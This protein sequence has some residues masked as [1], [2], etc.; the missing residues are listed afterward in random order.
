MKFISPLLLMITACG[1]SSLPARLIGQA[2]QASDIHADA[3]LAGSAL[4]DAPAHLAAPGQHSAD[5]L[6]VQS[7]ARVADTTQPSGSG[8]PTEDAPP[9]SDRKPANTLAINQTVRDQSD[10]QINPAMFDKHLL[11]NRIWISGQANFIFQ[12]HGAFHSPYAGTNSFQSTREQTALSRVLT[13]YTGVRFAKYSEF[14]FDPEETGGKGLSEALGIA[15]FTNLD[16]VRNPSL[17]QNVYLGRYMLHETIPLSHETIKYD[18]NPFYLAQEVPKKRIEIHF[19][20]MG[21]VDFFDVNDVGSDSHL[22]FTN[23]SLDNNGAYDYAADTR[24]YTIGAVIEYQSPTFGIRFGEA[25]MPTVANGITLDY[26]LRRARAQNLELEFRPDWLPGKKT[27]IRPLAYLNDANMGDYRQAINAYLDGKDATPDVTLHRHQGSVKQGF[28]IN[29]EQELPK[30]LRVFGRVGWNEGHKE[31]F[32]YTEINNTFTLGADVSGEAWHRPLDKIGSAFADN[33]IS[34]DHREYLA[35]GGLG[36]ILG[37]GRLNYGREMI[38]E[39]YY[40][41]H[42]YRGLYAAVQLSYVDNPGYNQ[43]RGPVLVPGI[44]AHMDF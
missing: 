37:D 6:F 33:G 34:Q 43:D 13:L 12:A 16:V 9:Q 19:G 44:R 15:G 36:F 2:R 28:G 4:P 10:D 20:K 3:A 18:P 8:Q 27:V 35:L 17:G 24:G 21:L 23:W 39:S 26:A 42:L 31:S 32:A 1:I 38:S 29:V 30:N 14:L 40:N 11:F 22:Q 41:A 7:A 25:L 5:S